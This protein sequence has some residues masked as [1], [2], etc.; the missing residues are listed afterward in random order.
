MA[1]TVVQ[2]CNLCNPPKGSLIGPQSPPALTANGRD[3]SASLGWLYDG[4]MYAM[5]KRHQQVWKFLDSCMNALGDTSP[6]S[7]GWPCDGLV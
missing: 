5:E 1:V 2:A 3:T 4:C 6:A 7:L